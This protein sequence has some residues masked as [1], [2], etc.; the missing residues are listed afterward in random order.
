MKFG[1]GQS[2]RRLEDDRLIRGEG[3]FVDDIVCADALHMAILRSSHAHARI[4]SVD[5]EAARRAEGVVAAATGEDLARAGLNPIPVLRDYRAPDGSS[6]KVPPRWPLARQFVRHIGEPV[7]AVVAT[8]QQ[9]AHDA[10]EAIAFEVEELAPVIGLEGAGKDFPLVWP[11]AGTNVVVA[12]RL[13]DQA[14][15]DNAFA[16]AAHIAELSVTNQ[17]L[18][19][20]PLEP[21]SVL[22]MPDGG[23][24]RIVLYTASQNP[25]AVHEALTKHV[26]NW[27]G[28]RLRILVP[29]IGGGF[30]MKGY[31]YPEDAIAIYFAEYLHRPVRWTAS[32]S[33]EFAGS[34]HARDQLTDGALALDREG[35]ILALRVKSRTNLGA[36][37]TP[38]GPLIA[39]TLGSKVITNVYDI[40]CVD[41]E[42]QGLLTHT[43]PTAPYRGAGR[44]EAIF[45]IER[46]MDK[47]A[48]QIGIDRIELRRRN[49]I[50]P[51]QMPYRTPTGE[52]YDSGGFEAILDRALHESDWTGFE[53]RRA[54]SAMKGRLRGQGF[55]MFVEWTGAHAY[56]E[57]VD[58]SIRADG[59]IEVVSAT[60]PMGQGLVTSFAQMVAATFEV[61]PSR[62]VVVTGD[63]DRARGFGSFGSRSLIVGGSAIVVGA[64]EALASCKA[65]AADYLEAAVE[66]IAYEAG[67]FRIVGTDRSVDL[68]DL[69]AER[70]EKAIAS[71]HTGEITSGSWPNGAYVCEV[72]I[73][74]ETGAVSIASFTCVDDVGVVVNPM[75]VEGQVQGGVAQGI[76]QALMEQVIYER[77]S[78][79][80]LTA[81]FQDYCMPRADDLPMIDC[82]TDERWPCLTNPL[83]SK[84]VGESGTVGATPAVASAVL[85]ALRQVGISDIEMPITPH[86]IWQALQDRTVQEIF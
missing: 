51:R 68:F 85:D 1:A 14:A 16:Q 79:Q 78:G 24:D 37:P 70:N 44:P 60:Q 61:E 75:I 20:A 49:L 66:D 9:A 15:V 58:I 83:G 39:T 46:L 28:D 69:A 53:V 2:I 56:T 57:N 74:P 6:M 3:R 30:G 35:R 10:A 33:D 32:R 38:A 48:A 42:A 72:E 62:I 71:R 80:L 8:S 12:R 73:D 52:V 84:G 82:H 18:S 11:N 13:G 17:R 7:A 21:R 63:T 29:D 4:L 23:S 41:I 27:C 65:A 77:S 45:L 5:V 54:E 76:G 67:R 36:Y 26:F 34:A 50:S 25:T 55:A 31:L 40:P 43:Q 59:T 22:A 86:R 81:S 47:A 64:R 19:A